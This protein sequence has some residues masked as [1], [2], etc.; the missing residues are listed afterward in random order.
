M[1]ITKD[2]EVLILKT[3]KLLLSIILAIALLLGNIPGVIATPPAAP[4]PVK[5]LVVHFIDVGQAD[6]TLIQMPDGKVSLIDAGNAKD[7]T[8]IINYIK[9]LGIKK[10]DFVI[11][12][13]PHED[14]IGGMAEVIKA[15]EIG[16]IYMPKVA[17]TTKTYEN[18]LLTIKSK[19]LLIDTPKAGTD[20]YLTKEIKYSLLAPVAATYKEMND[21]SIV[22]KLTY[23]NNSFL[24]AGDAEKLS[25][26]QI[27]AAKYSLKADVLKVGHHGS[28]TSSSPAFVKAVSPKYSIIS[29][30]AG[31]TYNHPDNIIINRL[32]TYG[33]VHRTDLEGTI[34][35][36]SDGTNLTLKAPKVANVT[37]PVPKPSVVTPVKPTAP[38]TP[39]A[40]IDS[41]VYVTKTGTKYHRAN[42]S[43]LSQSKIEIKLSDAKAKGFEPCDKCKP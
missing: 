7:A 29:V 8:T 41:V 28:T 37:A 5:N 31:N 13:H 43:S 21:Y 17:A 38:T 22:T 2:K 12:T 15:F 19:K 26:D 11:G 4:V 36:T 1:V 20:I 33:E 10:L 42:C 39:A 9:A 3:R 30:G 23:K 24:F 27:I 18:L 40:P 6:S 14:H 35:V 25:E 34:T 16:K 32:K